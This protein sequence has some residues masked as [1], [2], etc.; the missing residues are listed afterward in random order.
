MATI[1]IPREEWVRF[2]DDFS[3]RHLG[4]IVTLEVLDSDLGDQEAATSLPL[5]GVSADVKRPE[6][7]IEIT[8]GTKP[9]SH[10]TRIINHPKRV[11][12]GRPETLEI[13]SIEVECETGSTTLLTFRYIP[14]YKSE[15]ILPEKL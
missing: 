4:W 14:I 1:E 2:F 9:D 12:L 10:I 6:T 8:I 15:R 5:A 3:T 7:C 11:W 13:E